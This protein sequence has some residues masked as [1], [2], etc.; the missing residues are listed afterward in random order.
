MSECQ[1]FLSPLMEGLDLDLNTRYQ[2]AHLTADLTM[3]MFCIP[4]LETQGSPLLSDTKSAQ[5]MCVYTSA[6]CRMS[7]GRT[8]PH[9]YLPFSPFRSTSATDYHP[10]SPMDTLDSQ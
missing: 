3:L 10:T 5:Q 7:P 8:P 2:L 9:L 6:G 4:P 1:S